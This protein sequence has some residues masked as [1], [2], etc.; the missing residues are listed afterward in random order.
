[1][2]TFR[3]DLDD[4]SSLRVT[5]N[6]ED[7]ARS[8]AERQLSA[9]APQ[10]A[11]GPNG[12]QAMAKAESGVTDY[13]WGAADA[14]MQGITDARQGAI[15][16]A[17]RLASPEALRK[18]AV[19]GPSYLQD[20]KDITSVITAPVA[21]P[22]TGAVKGGTELVGRPMAAA[23]EVVEGWMGG[24]RNREQLF[25]EM[26]PGVETALGAAGARSGVPAMRAPATVAREAATAEEAALRAQARAEAK[27]ARADEPSMV[28]EGLK[29]YGLSGLGLDVASALM[30]GFPGGGLAKGVLK[31]LIKGAVTEYKAGG[32]TSEA[33]AG[34][35]SVRQKLQNEMEAR[36]SQ[37]T[38]GPIATASQPPEGFG[39]ALDTAVGQINQPTMDLVRALN[40]AQPNARD[41][42]SSILAR[43]QLMQRT[44]N[45]ESFTP[46]PLP[47]E[48]AAAQALQRLRTMNSE[49][50]AGL[51]NMQR[52]FPPNPA[53][54][55]ALLA[56]ARPGSAPAPQM[57]PEPAPAAPAAPPAMPPAAPAAPMPPMAPAAPV[58]AAAGDIPQFLIDAARARNKVGPQPQRQMPQAPETVQAAAIRLKDGRVFTG[59]SHLDAMDN[60]KKAL[61]KSSVIDDI[62]TTNDGMGLFQTSTGRLV[63]REEAGVLQG[64]PGRLTAQD[65]FATPDDLS[66][67]TFL[68]RAPTKITVTK[69]DGGAVKVAEKPPM[70]QAAAK[71]DDDY[72]AS[73]RKSYDDVQKGDG[74]VLTSGDGDRELY[75]MRNTAADIT[76][77]RAAA[78]HYADMQ[79]ALG[80]PFKKS[81]E[82]FVKY[83]A[84][85]V[86]AK[87]GIA[88]RLARE[89]NLDEGM[90]RQHLRS[91]R[92]HEEAYAFR[93]ELQALEPEQASRIERAMPDDEIT[94]TWPIISEKK[95][96]SRTKSRKRKP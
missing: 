65:A 13:L 15:D 16:A 1:M 56:Q 4:G 80:K 89:T 69:A 78:E 36:A 53:E 52:P 47:V 29:N 64:K 10:K 28:K 34:L 12:Q 30:T 93:S 66:I 85:K 48:A 77:A 58:E 54:V 83:V 76:D 6:S 25:Q 42:M 79:I 67:P 9:P 74:N 84:E 55:E 90:L 88:K 73:L 37:A 61:G 26:A 86:A 8:I 3:I 41:P 18:R 5:A 92:D 31:S 95:K 24:D 46:P 20:A 2:A 62:D 81:R 82:S 39:A 43:A 45:K 60:I 50:D 91:I 94:G 21:A 22:V 96:P 68:Q 17:K 75:L 32:K 33:T 7:E 49:M 19:E 87:D 59:N 23:G 44:A 27:A 72:N 35:S 14:A 38:A 11:S 40:K 63:S 57:A 71:A 51:A 70:Q